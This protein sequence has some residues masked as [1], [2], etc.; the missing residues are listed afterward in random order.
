MLKS[1]NPR[2]CE[3][4][5]LIACYPRIALDLRAILAWMFVFLLVQRETKSDTSGH[6]LLHKLY[7]FKSSKQFV[8]Y[9]IL[10][11]T[12]LPYITYYMTC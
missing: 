5:T 7:G 1:K 2:Q 4:C 8:I 10:Q 11:W 9:R 12:G 3:N 6:C